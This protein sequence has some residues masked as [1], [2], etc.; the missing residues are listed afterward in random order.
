MNLTEPKISKTYQIPIQSLPFAIS[1]LTNQISH[2]L[3]RV[4]ID[5]IRRFS[6]LPSID[7]NIMLNFLSRYF[8][9]RTGVEPKQTL[10]IYIEEE[11]NKAEST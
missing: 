9:H 6:Q 5:D 7:I 3:T 10:R 8:I 11:L 1:A 4:L 2:Y